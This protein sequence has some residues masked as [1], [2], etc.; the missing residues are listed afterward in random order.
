MPSGRAILAARAIERCAGCR[1]ERPRGSAAACRCAAPR[2]QPYCTRCVKPFEGDL[3]PHCLA[4]AETNGRKL[5][6]SLDGLLAREGGLA[7]AASSLA[8]LRD[9]VESTLREFGLDSAAAPLPAWATALADPKGALPPGADRSRPKMAAI[10]E[11]RLEEA[12]L[13][14]ALAALGYSGRPSDEKLRKTLD[15]ATAAAAVLAEWDGLSAGAEHEQSLRSAADALAAAFLAAGLPRAESA[16]VEAARIEARY[17]AA[18]DIPPRTLPQ[19]LDRDARAISFT[20][21]CYLGQETV[22]RLDALGHVNR[23][24]VLVA[25]AA[26]EPPPPGA[27]VRQGG[28]E[29]GTV[30]SGCRSREPGSALVLAIVHVKALGGGPL[31]VG[32]AAG[33]VVPGTAGGGT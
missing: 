28:E 18:A 30:G 12:G 33:R 4:I 2:W 24:L 29:V 27:A 19:E 21:G 13:R 23:R 22:A 1:T 15:A 8:R 7:G 10:S 9:R 20:K 16:D 32:G 6:A 17:P 31:E 26:D 25:V 11:L 5:R 14:N 3:C